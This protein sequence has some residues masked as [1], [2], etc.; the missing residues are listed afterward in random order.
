MRYTRIEPVQT[1]AFVRIPGVAARAMGLMGYSLGPD[2]Y[3]LDT[4]GLAHPLVARFE[5]TPS[6]TWRRPRRPGHKKP[7]P[8][9]WLAAMVSPP[10]AR[11]LPEDFPG[12][13]NPLIPYVPNDHFEVQVDYVRAVLNAPEIRELY[14]A[15]TEPLDMRRWIKNMTG[16]YART[17]L[18]IPPD[19][20]QAFE[21]FCSEHSR[22]DDTWWQSND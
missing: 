21:K 12:V 9:V 17:K 5:T 3:I 10:D 4:F 7:L 6:L 20:Q 1:G 16:A 18:T 19:P 2:W 13:F 22:C 14:A 8:T 15:V 11:P